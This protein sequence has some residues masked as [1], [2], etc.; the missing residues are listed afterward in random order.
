MERGESFA[1]RW[2][3]V[4]LIEKKRR[5]EFA[6]GLFGL[7]VVCPL[8]ARDSTLVLQ[9][10]QPWEP[11]GVSLPVGLIHDF[12]QIPGARLI[13]DADVFPGPNQSS[14]AFSRRDAQTNRLSH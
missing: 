8:R 3:T 1:Y 4:Y 5:K 14:R 13:G 11:W 6:Q 9:G 12:A 2:P 7:E 10:L